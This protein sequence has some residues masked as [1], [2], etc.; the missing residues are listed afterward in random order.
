MHTAHPSPRSGF[1][2][3][4]LLVVIAI[5]GLLMALLLPAVQAAREAG[6]RAACLNNLKQLG[7]ALHQFHDS[8]R[9]FPPGRGG[10]APLVFSPHAFLL[11]L[12]EQDGLYHGLDLTSAPTNLVIGGVPYSGAAN[13][14]AAAEVVGV[15]TCPSDPPGGRIRGL[16]FGGTNYIACTGSGTV[17][18]GTLAGATGT[19]A[20][21]DGVFFLASKIRF[22]D[23]S[24]G[25]SHTAAFSERTLGPGVAPTAPPSAPATNYIWELGTVS[26]FSAANC[27]AAAGGS[28]F[29]QRGGKWILGNY[30]NTL[31][32]HFW[33]PNSR[34]WDCM[35]LAQQ[36]G[37]FAARSQ[38][39][40]GVGALWCDG[41]ARTVA[42]TVAL[43][44]WRAASTRAGSETLQLE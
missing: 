37:R 38:H 11:P 43:E 35:N 10:P 34:G 7:L 41:S 30:G 3:V 31:Y 8:Q 9:R 23:I 5:V 24:D 44:V 15:L 19:L 2:L 13:A 4:E 27:D 42:D 21:A 20:G 1:T 14:A 18:D 22:A 17:G 32:N 36:K 29:V 6:R 28:W 33:P 12:V 26:G 25:T 40:G 39:P 16:K